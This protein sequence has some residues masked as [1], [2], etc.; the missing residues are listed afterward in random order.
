MCGVAKHALTGAG[1]LTNGPDIY[2]WPVI[3]VPHKQLWGAVPARGHVV[4]Q[5]VAAAAAAGA[6][7]RKAEVAQLDNALVRDQDVL[8]LHVPVQ[9]WHLHAACSKIIG[10]SRDSCKKMKRIAGAVP[11]AAPCTVHGDVTSCTA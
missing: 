1:G 6:R 2:G 8:R 4:R 5:R 11:H 3:G 9:Q 7:A 10:N